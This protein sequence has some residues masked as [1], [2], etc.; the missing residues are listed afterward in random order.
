M[1]LDKIVKTLKDYFKTDNIPNPHNYPESFMF[2]VTIY[3]YL[4]RERK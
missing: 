2:Y 3:K 4:K 1:S